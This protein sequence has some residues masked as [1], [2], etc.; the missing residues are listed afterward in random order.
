AR[1]L[2]VY[3]GKD[4]LIEPKISRELATSFSDHRA[5]ACKDNDD[6]SEE[7]VIQETRE[8]FSKEAK[9]VSVNFEMSGHFLQ[10]DRARYIADS[11]EAILRSQI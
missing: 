10:R 11:I 5:L 6:V 1:V 3:A 2:V 8:L 7:K 9:T 4:M